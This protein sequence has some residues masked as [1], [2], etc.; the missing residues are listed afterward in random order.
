MTKP[1]EAEQE[2]PAL[3]L[4]KPCARFACQASLPLVWII[5]LG[6]VY[7]LGLFR[8][9]GPLTR[10]LFNS[11]RFWLKTGSR[12]WLSWG[13]LKHSA[14]FLLSGV[15]KFVVCGS[16]VISERKQKRKDSLARQ[17]DA[18]LLWSVPSYPKHGDFCCFSVYIVGTLHRV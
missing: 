16:Q 12:C 18:Q 5:N 14:H 8:V 7:P 9:A 4:G 10:P 3:S 2:A 17:D 11:F 1:Q 13:A 15:W 6:P